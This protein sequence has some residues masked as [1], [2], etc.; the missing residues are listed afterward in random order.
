[1]PTNKP[2]VNV[3]ME[4]DV[5]DVISEFC[6]LSKRSMSSFLAQS[7]ADSAPIIAKL[8]PLL[9][10]AEQMNEETRRATAAVMEKLDS[11]LESSISSLMAA[12]VTPI[13]NRPSDCDDVSAAGLESVLPPSINKGVRFSEKE[14]E[15]KDKSNIYSILEK[16][17]KGR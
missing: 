5:Y 11:D 3:V 2:R 12:A 17:G 14:A 15:S 9:R 7:A 16:M 4:Q 6:K 13:A 1:M 8:I 10:V